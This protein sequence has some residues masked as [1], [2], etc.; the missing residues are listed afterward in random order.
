[1]AT[2]TGRLPI[3]IDATSN[4]EF[5]PVPVSRTVAEAKALAAARIE[6]NARRTALP[7][8]AFLVGLCGAATTLLTLNRAFAARGN[9]GGAFRVHPEGA[10]E[11]REEALRFLSL[12]FKKA[13]DDDL[14]RQ[15]AALAFTT[16]Q[17][18][19]N[20]IAT[21]MAPPDDRPAT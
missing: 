20:A 21:A 12:A 1:M 11:H 19:E 3:K 18:A 2:R 5:R 10:F 6:E 8:R 9:L 4:G 15:A 7:R 16:M 17:E 13:R 14:A